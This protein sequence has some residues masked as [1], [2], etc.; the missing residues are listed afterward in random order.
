MKR[1]VSLPGTRKAAKEVQSS[2]CLDAF[3]SSPFGGMDGER[4]EL[5][6]K[7]VPSLRAVCEAKSVTLTFVDLRWGIS[8]KQARENLILRIC[9]QEVE[10]ADVFIGMYGIRY[11]SSLLVP[12]NEPWLRPTIESCFDQYPWLRDLP[13]RSLTEFEFR[14]GCLNDVDKTPAF[15]YFRDKT[16]D[17]AMAE[18]ARQANDLRQVRAYSVENEASEAA[19]ARVQREIAELSQAGRVV[20]RSDYRDPKDGVE[21][22]SADLHSLLEVLL[23]SAGVSAEEK[24][25][26]THRAFAQVT[27]ETT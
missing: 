6:R 8:E 19:L 21:L 24:K 10:R 3:L 26:S 11:G 18:K 23:P 12:E 22:L 9:L 5:M 2:R 13:E 25:I 7:H 16:F 20:Y 14:H 15:F 1:N 17:E 4:E 27:T